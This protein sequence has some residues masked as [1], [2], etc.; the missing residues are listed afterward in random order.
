MVFA[1]PVEWVLAGARFQVEFFFALA[2]NKF[3]SNF[4]S[5]VR[6]SRTFLNGPRLA[7]H[8]SIAARPRIGFQKK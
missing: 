7:D 8:F 5:K 3:Q 2:L 1:P 4:A 6:I